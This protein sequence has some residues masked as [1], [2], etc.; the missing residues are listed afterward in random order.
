M[1]IN[2]EYLSHSRIEV[3][4]QCPRLFKLRYIDK[5]ESENPV[6]DY[7]AKYGTLLHYLTE[8]YFKSHGLIPKQ[9]LFDIFVN[10]TKDEDGREI[11]GFNSIEFPLYRGKPY[12][13]DKYYKQGVDYI[14]RL[15]TYDT[16]KTVGVEQEFTIH[17]ADGVPL[18]R[19]VIDRLDKTEDGYEVWDYKTSASYGQ[20]KCDVLPQVSIY[21]LAVKDMYGVIPKRIVYDFI[22][23]ND[24]IETH[25]SEEQLEQTKQDIIQ[26]W[27]EITR[28][29]FAPRYDER[30]CNLFCD[31]R[32]SCPL[33][34][35]MQKG[36]ESE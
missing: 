14:E 30:Y 12:M 1:D 31:H 20:E 5:A 2:M 32:V 17:I 10:G 8:I 22:R 24:R 15:V 4:K 35:E 6:S 36:G 25:R 26:T 21:A 19:G 23:V 33:Y 18:L 11:A 7:F 16:S 3:F 34:Q 9:V 13:R 28:S 29:D 27:Y